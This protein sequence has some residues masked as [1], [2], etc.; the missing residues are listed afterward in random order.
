MGMAYF[1]AMHDI[2]LKAIKKFP[3]ID[4]KTRRRAAKEFDLE[5]LRQGLGV[6]RFDVSA[7][8]LF[9]LAFISNGDIDGRIKKPI[10]KR[11]FLQPDYEMDVSRLTDEQVNTILWSA[12][13]FLRH[14]GEENYNDFIKS[15]GEWN[16]SMI[17]KNNPFI[18]F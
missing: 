4:L 14:M 6:F 16:N 8:V 18:P 13:S 1:N 12:M 7:A 5:M 15:L 3:E 9:Y 11:A 2:F 17:G 10:A